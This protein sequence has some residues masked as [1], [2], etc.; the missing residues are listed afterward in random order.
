MKNEIEKLRE[1]APGERFSEFHHRMR[2]QGPSWLRPLYLA[3]AA[4]AFAIGVVLAFIPGPA[5]LFFA[6][7]AA[8]SGPVTL[9]GHR[10][11]R[12]EVK[13]R[14]WVD[15]PDA[16]GLRSRDRGFRGGSRAATPHCAGDSWDRMWSG[17]RDLGLWRY[18]G[19]QLRR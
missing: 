1:A 4:V 19:M 16:E 2:T 6:L 14:E 17:A 10:L 18:H 7:A 12:A 9:V 15:S 13:L 8:H 3:A 11:D 5:V